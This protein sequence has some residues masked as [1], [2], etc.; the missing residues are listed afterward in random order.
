MLEVGVGL[1]REPEKTL[2]RSAFRVVSRRGVWCSKNR[3]KL[4]AWAPR[5]ALEVGCGWVWRPACSNREALGDQKGV[6]GSSKEEGAAGLA[7]GILKG[8]EG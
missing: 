2:M 4:E 5:S 8:E 7:S 6:P 1:G 3:R